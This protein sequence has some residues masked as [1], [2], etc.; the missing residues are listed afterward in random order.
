[1]SYGHLAAWLHA[2]TSRV[3]VPL[4]NDPSVF[5]RCKGTGGV[6]FI[7]FLPDEDW[8][9]G[10]DIMQRV[11]ERVYVLPNIVAGKF[12]T[13]SLPVHFAWAQADHQPAVRKTLDL[14][15]VPSVVAVNPRKGVFAKFVCWCFTAV[16]VVGVAC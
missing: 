15:F 4:I 6:W 16:F 1:M 5:E 2:Q 10:F 11:S 13:E 14:D 3:P 8:K 12:T 7:A 9:Q